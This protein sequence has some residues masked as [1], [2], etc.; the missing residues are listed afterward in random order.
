MCPR[1]PNPAIR[2]HNSRL[3]LRDHWVL[4][5]TV[6]T[7]FHV[8]GTVA[9]SIDGSAISGATVSLVIDTR[10]GLVPAK[11]VL[12]Y[13]IGRYVVDHP[14]N[15]G[16]DVCPALWM[17]SAAAGYVATPPRD[18]RYP[19]TCGVPTQTINIALMPVP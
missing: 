14:F 13:A 19:V 6:Q 7:V 9:S 5:P 18:A 16:K 15:L 17:T 12:T 3:W 10:D 1:A 4:R 8:E 11:T 2:V